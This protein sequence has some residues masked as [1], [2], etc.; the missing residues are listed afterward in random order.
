MHQH[1]KGKPFVVNDA[2]W[3]IIAQC[4]V[5]IVFSPWIWMLWDIKAMGSFLVGGLI[6]VVPNSYLYVRVFSHFGAR[7]AKQIVHAFYVGEALKFVLTAVCF[8]GALFI[9]W[10][11]PLWLLVGFIV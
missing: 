2:L 8:V 9:V 6:C 4:V 11:L 1:R 7:R 3:G 5:V 10:T